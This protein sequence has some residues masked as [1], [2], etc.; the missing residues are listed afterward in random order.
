[1]F[2][3]TTTHQCSTRKRD[4]PVNDNEQQRALPIPLS[5]SDMAPFASM[6]DRYDEAL[7]SAGRA[8]NRA[9]SHDVFAT[10]RASC[11]P[12][13]LLRHG[14][15]LR[16][17]S[18]FLASFGVQRSAEALSSEPAAW[19]GMTYGILAA[20]RRWLEGKGEA[21]GTI[22]AR[23]ATIHQYCKLAGPPPQGAGVLDGLE[24]SAILNVKGYTGKI[25]RN[26]DEERRRQGI[27]TR[28]GRKKAT[29]T[30]ITAQQAEKLKRTTMPS[31]P[32]QRIPRDHDQLLAAR[33]SLM[34][35]L[36]IEHALRCS[37]LVALDVE[38]IDLGHHRLSIYSEKTH[39]HNVHRLQE[40]TEAAAQVYLGQ[41]GRSNG[42]LFEGYSGQ[43]IT[44]R[45]VNK[46]VGVI[47]DL[48]GFKERRLSPHDLRHFFTFDALEHGLSLDLVQAIGGWTS[49]YMPLLYAKRTMVRQWKIERG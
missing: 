32:P 47:G 31:P 21:I 41:L 13:T 39:T 26:L 18:A 29:F 7:S 25:A 10:Y 14:Y 48:L 11:R 20:F 8:A 46:R 49:P 17:F 24:L 28:V 4:T 45:A 36:F 3:N 15:D 44:T 5:A 30:S 1:M 19:R 34:F 40:H 37:E 16:A 27:P 2:P 35:C 12:N 6:H 43:R 33:D 38:S 22:K 42:P 9:F 23:V